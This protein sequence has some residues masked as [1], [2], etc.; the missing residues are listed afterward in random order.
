MVVG[1]IGLSGCYNEDPGPLQ[2]TERAYTVV[3][4]DRLEISSGLHI[5]VK[6]GEFYAVSARGDRR[7][8]DDLIVEKEGSTLVVR[9]RNARPRRHDTFIEI[10]SPLLKAV[11]F[12]GGCNGKVSGF[13][14]ED[15]FLVY[16]SGGTLCQLDVEATDMK[17][18][19]SGGSQLNL[20]GEAQSMDADVSGA[21]ALRAFDFPVDNAEVKLT[22]ASDVQVTVRESLNVVATGASHL[23]YRGAPTVSSDVSGASSIEKE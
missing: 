23:I 21:S 15:S 16:L 13:N 8:I 17:I 18:V 6:H 5:T 7:N 3:D 2:M 9:Y 10:T 11:L 1:I 19:L 22:G 20:G 14:A 4:F 12:S